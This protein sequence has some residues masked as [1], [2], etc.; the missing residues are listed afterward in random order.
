MIGTWPTAYAD[1]FRAI[2]E[3]GPNWIKMNRVALM[4]PYTSFGL[5]PP[6]PGHL[7]SFY[8]EGYGQKRFVL[9]LNLFLGP[10]P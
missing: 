10:A 7:T 9:R 1:P 8:N 5:Y 2:R 3:Q 6:S 4:C